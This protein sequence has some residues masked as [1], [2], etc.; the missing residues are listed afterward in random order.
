MNP[1]RKSTLEK[2]NEESLLI[3]GS[4]LSL[5]QCGFLLVGDSG[6]GKTTLALRAEKH[7]FSFLADDAVRFQIRDGRA[8]GGANHAQ[9]Q[10][11]ELS[12][13]VLFDQVE[14]SIVLDRLCLR[15]SN[16]K[17]VSA[18]EFMRDWL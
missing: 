3:H 1:S 15:V 17:M 18:T 10:R 13:I 5:D 4:Y 11:S 7:G 14:N 2:T 8:I 12:Y 6:S 16:F 9:S